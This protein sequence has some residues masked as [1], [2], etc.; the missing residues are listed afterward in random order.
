MKILLSGGSSGFGRYLKENLGNCILYGRSNYTRHEN[1]DVIIHCGWSRSFESSI[2]DYVYEAVLHAS[3]LIKIPHKKF[4]FLSTAKIYDGQ[5]I[6]DWGE[7]ME[8]SCKIDKRDLVG[9]Y[10]STKLLVEE[11]VTKRA[12]NPVIIRPSSLMGK[13]TDN[14]ITKL[15]QMKPANLSINSVMNLVLY[16][17]VMT[18]IQAC[19]LLDITG[20]F[21]LVGKGNFSLSE[22][23]KDLGLFGNH[24][25]TNGNLSYRKVDELLPNILQT[26]K[27]NYNTWKHNYAKNK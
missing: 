21:N 20:V 18:F 7:E 3:N 11:M 17:H 13:Y 12:T 16:E 5:R 26:S 9:I 24:I 1:V 4:I 19:F 23:T 8:E 25:E 2:M 27:N 15:A 6:I 22:T 10:S 14:S